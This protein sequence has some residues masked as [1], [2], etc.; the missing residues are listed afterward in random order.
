MTDFSTFVIGS[1]ALLLIGYG[2]GWFDSKN[3]HNKKKD[4]TS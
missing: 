1:L 3:Y 4:E 2:C